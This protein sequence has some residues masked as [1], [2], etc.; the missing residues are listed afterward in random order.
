MKSIR[1]AKFWWAGALVIFFSVWVVIN[2][3]HLSWAKYP[4]KNVRVIVHSPPG[5]GVDLMARLVLKYLERKLGRAFILENNAGA[6]GQV[7]WT[8]LSM[9]KPDGYTIGTSS[10]SIATHELTR[11]G[12]PYT[13]RDN[14][15]PIAR[16]VLDPSALFALSDSPYKNLDD[17][18]REAKKNPGKI[19]SGGT[20]LWGV[21]HVHLLLL[22]KLANIKLIY[23]PF[24]GAAESRTSL[25]GGHLGVGSGGVSEYAGLVKQGKIR[26]LAI[27]APK[28]M[29]DL[30]DA[31][32][33][34]EMGYDLNFGSDRGFIAPAG[35][36]KEII[37]ILSKGIRE[38]LEDREFLAEA[39]KVGIASTIYYLNAD[40][41]RNDLVANQE[42]MKESLKDLKPK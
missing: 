14:F 23:I 17:L 8:A 39:T 22:Q 38:V 10:W 24:D 15:A 20:F 19:T 13:L 5:G 42:V 11:K 27:A 41:Y 21:H 34:K 12:V 1:G 18:I 31:L 2:T 40:D 16:V 25:L 29:I 28:R 30:P 9:A 6:G 26:A 37:E 4:E 33:Y 36:P 7:G 3:P 32:T 35:T